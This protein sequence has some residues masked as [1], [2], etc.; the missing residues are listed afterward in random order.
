MAHSTDTYNTNHAGRQ[1]V[2]AGLMITKIILL[3]L[4]N[5]LAL[6]AIPILW[7]DSQWILLGVLVIATAGID[8]AFLSKKAL[9]LRFMLPGLLFM[10]IMVIFP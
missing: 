6:W 1:P 7:G 3:G 5:A 8:Y 9:P 4:L 2:K 10:M